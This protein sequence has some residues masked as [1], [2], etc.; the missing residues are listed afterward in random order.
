MRKNWDYPD[1]IIQLALKHGSM[2]DFIKNSAGAWQAAKRFGIDKKI[3]SLM[4][5]KKTRAYTYEELKEFALSCGTRGEF[6]KKSPSKY[7]AAR[8]MEILDEICS[9]MPPPKTEAYTYEELEALV[10]TCSSN[11]EF[12]D[13]YPGAYTVACSRKVLKKLCKDFPEAKNKKHTREE[14]VAFFGKDGYEV[15]SEKYVNANTRLETICPAGHT[16]FVRYG[17]FYTGYR[18]AD[19]VLNNVSKMELE[20][21]EALRKYV[22]ELKRKK[23]KVTV[24]NKSHIKAF[25]VDMYDS[26]KKIGIEF[27][28][29]YYHSFEYMRSD[30]KKKKWSDEDIRNYHEIKDSAL[31]DCHGILVLHIKEEEW[32]VDKQA[33][34]NKAL[35]FL[36]V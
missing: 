7:N 1:E 15:V 34:I 20:L 24:L 28:G 26:E 33:C 2:T 6:K 30:K 23:F 4:P 3:K 18:C 19:C 22:P 17:D 9:H 13:K 32:K 35:R 10:K 11:Q 5:V 31:M 16:Y 14:V 36:G 21:L 8:D 25:E 12:R 29:E 27:D